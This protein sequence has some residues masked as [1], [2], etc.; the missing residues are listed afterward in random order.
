MVIIGIGIGIPATLASGSI[1]ESDL[2]G[3]G[4]RN[5]LVLA[6]VCLLVAAK[7]LLAAYLPARR[8]MQVDPSVALRYE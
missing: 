1:L 5:P 8:A 3:T 2:Y 7:G 4:A 6:G